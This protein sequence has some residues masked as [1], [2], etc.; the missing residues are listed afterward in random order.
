MAFV[1]AFLWCTGRTKGLPILPIFALTFIPAY[2]LPV[3]TSSRVLRAYSAE[4]QAEGVLIAA[5]YLGLITLIWQQISSRSAEPRRL[6][7]AI[8]PDRSAPWLLGFMAAYLFYL[9]LGQELL[10]ER[11]GLKALLAGI[12][13][14]AS[15][16]A[17]FVFSYQLG[18]RELKPQVAGSFFLLFAGLS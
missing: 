15:A 10:G 5:L 2:A 12:F 18:K 16:V 11:T 4:Q 9:A 7:Y 1:P 8:D 3:Q 17:V 13:R 6:T 14:N